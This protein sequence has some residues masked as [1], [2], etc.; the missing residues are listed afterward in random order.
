M[1]LNNEGT[2]EEHDEGHVEKHVEKHVEEHVE[3]HDEGHVD[4]EQARR[5]AAARAQGWR[6]DKYGAGD[7]RNKSADQFLAD[8]ENILAK[9]RADND[10]LKRMLKT[11]EK[12]LERQKAD[13][14][15]RLEELNTKFNDAVALGDV[16]Q[17]NKIQ[18]QRESVKGAIADAEAFNADARAPAP[19][20]EAQAWAARNPWFKDTDPNDSL[21]LAAVSYGRMVKERNPGIAPQDLFNLIDAHMDKVA[22]QRHGGRRQ[23]SAAVDDGGNFT[24]AAGSATTA[25]N[26][27]RINGRL[28]TY[29]DLPPAARNMCDR[30]TADGSTVAEYLKDY[31]GE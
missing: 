30:Y 10:Q 13:Y 27:A 26:S 29:N 6:P 3:E 19:T 15:A 4:N 18:A 28:Y 7:P 9:A 20:M 22:P 14:E 23:Q 1:A 5:E 16:E 21:T 25:K 24:G 12:F 17:V 31:F 11:Q 2:G 8:G